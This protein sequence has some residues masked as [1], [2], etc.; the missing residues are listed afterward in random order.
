MR[1]VLAC[2]S[3]FLLWGAKGASHQNDAS[4]NPRESFL[5][6]I[7]ANS[8]Y[9][10]SPTT[11]T[12][13]NIPLKVGIIGAGAA[14]LYAAVLLDS[15]GIEYDII[16][17]SDRVGGRIYTYRFDE[18]A[19]LNSTPDDPEY[20]D[21]FDVGAMRFPGMDYMA[22]I[23]GTS[24]N[25][26][27]SY[28]NARVSSPKDKIVQIPYIYTADN[29]FR[30]Y[31][32]VL[33]Y[34][35]DPPTADAFNTELTDN[36][37]VDAQFA[38]LDPTK[39]WA[40]VTKTL[41]SALTANFTEGFNLLMDYDYQSIRSYLISQ[42]YTG[43]QIDWME[44][45]DDATDHYD[46]YSMS[47]GVLEQ[48][49]FTESSLDNW[50]CVNGGMDRLTYGMEQ[51]ISS[52]PILNSQVTAIKPASDGQLS[53]EI[54]YKK[55]Q[56]Y[57]HVISTIPLGALQIV[58]L[59]ELDL[60]YAQR[61]AI[62]K[63][64]YDPALKI[65]I[66]FKTRWWEKLPA[67]FQGG[68][69][70]SDHPLRRCVYP[71][72]GFDLPGDTA[73]GTMI[74][75]YIWGQDSTRLGAYLRTPEARATLVKVVLYDLAAM[76]NVTL[77]FIESEYIDYYA[78]DWYQDQWSVGAFAIFS[79]GQYHDVMPSLMVPAENGHLHFGGEALSSGHAWVIG[80]VNSAYR[81]VL[82]VLKTEERDDLIEK[83]V[84]TWGTIEE[85]D[86]GWYTHI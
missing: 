23:T 78:W 73:P 59:T 36:G 31:N 68:Q 77:E 19:W 53:V 84:Q 86:L 35:Q 22:R 66:K 29:T 10:N 28:I 16:E 14:G 30:L 12:P 76:N 32:E 21:Y 49:I 18:T 27:I 54:D 26:L 74:A 37:T 57:A 82:E 3:L 64:N 61:H 85:V 4:S 67:P 79:P 34:N 13:K 52:K 46:M 1:L 47:Q 75:S 83:L 55:E 33:L 7:L 11:P 8:K 38:Q 41:T 17:A 81:T 58:D 15:L 50:T 2:I 56:T 43:P 45:I 72:Y 48:W 24:N 51:I 71:S 42:G 62:R 63:L 70:Y 69:S 40:S 6:E 65:G 60:G 44:T 80:A 5:R 9:P 20:Y 39:V 25:S